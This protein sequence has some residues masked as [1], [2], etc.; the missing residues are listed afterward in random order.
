MKR[1]LCIL[2]LLAMTSSTWC[3]MLTPTR[4]KSPKGAL[5]PQYFYQDACGKLP[6]YGEYYSQSGDGNSRW[7]D[8]PERWYENLEVIA[9]YSTL[10]MVILRKD[11]EAHITA[12]TDLVMAAVER[13]QL[14]CLSSYDKEGVDRAARLLDML[15]GRSGGQAVIRNILC[16]KLMDEPY[17]G[18]QSPEQLEELIGY[19]D[20]Q[21]KSRYPHLLSLVNFAVSNQD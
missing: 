14:L 10:Y 5:V 7:Y 21:L 3:Q 16:V 13:G 9:P 11:D 15:E 18:G 8:N 12:Y 17:L 2:L 19:F 4:Y 1:L 6:F 20:S